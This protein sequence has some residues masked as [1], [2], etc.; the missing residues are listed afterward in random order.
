MA[1]RPSLLGAGRE[2][3]AATRT[4]TPEAPTVHA[5]ESPASKVTLRAPAAKQRRYAAAAETCGVQLLQDIT[6]DAKAAPRFVLGA[7]VGVL[8]R[9]PAVVKRIGTIT[10]FAR[11]TAMRA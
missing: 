11:P 9:V 7:A 8:K 5:K 4:P 10:E 2:A 3:A 6:D 1:K